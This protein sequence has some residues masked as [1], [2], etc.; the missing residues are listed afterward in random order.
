MVKIEKAVK[1]DHCRVN[2]PTQTSDLHLDQRDLLHVATAVKQ[3]VSLP[4]H[5]HQHTP[6]PYSQGLHQGNQNMSNQ[7]T[8]M[9]TITP[10][11]PRTAYFKPSANMR[12]AH[13]KSLGGNRR[14]CDSGAFIQA[15]EIQIFLG[16]KDKKALSGTT[17]S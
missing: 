1:C 7:H 8:G 6:P 2:A 5:H 13:A 3:Q 16:L 12:L 10:C 17:K 11:L 4:C 9:C 14:R 15:P